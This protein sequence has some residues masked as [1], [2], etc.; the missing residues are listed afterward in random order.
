MP[1]VMALR[2]VNGR[3]QVDCGPLPPAPASECRNQFGPKE[4]AMISL[5]IIVV[6]G[7]ATAVGLGALLAEP[8]P[9]RDANRVLPYE[10]YAQTTATRP[11]STHSRS[12]ESARSSQ[13]REA[14]VARDRRARHDAAKPETRR[15]PMPA[16]ACV[17]CTRVRLARRVW[18]RQ[19]G[20]RALILGAVKNDPS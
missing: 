15:A 5:L 11:T 20:H 1:C 10:P 6:F 16:V 13:R 2:D 19:G 14:G 18:E 9:L 3:E 12:S 17:L 8:R 4:E 7:L